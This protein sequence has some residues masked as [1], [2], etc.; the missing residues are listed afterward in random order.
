M[1]RFSVSTPEKTKNFRNNRNNKMIDSLNTDEKIYV[2]KLNNTII[3]L[4]FG[5]NPLEEQK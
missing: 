4:S 2:K 3:H 1:Y 5:K